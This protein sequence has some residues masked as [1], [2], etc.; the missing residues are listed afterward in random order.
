MSPSWRRWGKALYSGM[1]NAAGGVIDD[2][3]VYLTA[4]ATAWW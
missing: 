2:L 3:I 4:W 1:L